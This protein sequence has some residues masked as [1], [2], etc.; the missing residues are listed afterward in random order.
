M[1]HTYVCHKNMVVISKSIVG[2]VDRFNIILEFN[3]QPLY[4]YL[5]ILHFFTSNQF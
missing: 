1:Y 2:G 5:S 3:F 4:Y